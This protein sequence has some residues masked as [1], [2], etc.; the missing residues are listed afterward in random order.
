VISRVIGGEPKMSRWGGYIV[1]KQYTV[2]VSSMAQGPLEAAISHEGV[3]GSYRTAVQ[4]NLF[5]KAL[6]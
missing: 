3:I 5:H 6:E 1:L 4:Y 2:T